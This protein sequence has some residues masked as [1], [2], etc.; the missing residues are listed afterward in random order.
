MSLGLTGQNMID[1]VSNALHLPVGKQTEVLRWLNR[2]ALWMAKY[3]DW[4]DLRVSDASFT[5]DGSDSYD[6]TSEISSSFYRVIDKT[7][8]VGSRN[9]VPMPKSYMDEVDPLR[10]TSNSPT[11]YCAVSRKDFRMFP[12]GSDGD[13]VYLDYIRY[14]VEITSGLAA[15]GQSYDEPN[16]EL[17]VT[18]ALWRGEQRLGLSGWQ[19]NQ[20]AW[21]AEVRKAYDKGHIARYSPRQIMSNQPWSNHRSR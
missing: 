20:K 18:G 16:Q 12:Y 2:S 4:P 5:S 9:L 15:S 11:G 1:D 7:V 19:N 14:P 21:E 6:L 17:V 10:S 3:F 13:T 8:R